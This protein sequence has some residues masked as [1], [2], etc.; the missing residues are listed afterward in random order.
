M[1]QVP[2]AA[3]AEHGEGELL[4]PQAP[5]PLAFIRRHAHD[6]AEV[7]PPVADQG[8]GALAGRHDVEVRPRMAPRERWH[9]AAQVR[10]GARRPVGL[11]E[12]RV[13]ADVAGNPGHGRAS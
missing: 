12:Q 9:Q 2:A 11:V 6:R 10:L 5:R 3:R 13:D 7:R 1:Q 4:R 8:I